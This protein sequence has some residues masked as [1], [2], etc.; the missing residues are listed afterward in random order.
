ME[1]RGETPRIGPRTGATSR[2]TAPSTGATL[3]RTA[4]TPARSVPK[5]AA[6]A[7]GLHN[8]SRRTARAGDGR[9]RGATERGS[10][11]R[12]RRRLERTQSGQ[13]FRRGGGVER[14][15][16]SRGGG[17]GRRR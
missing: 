8:S 1:E 9:R 4:R 16:S 13:A 7:P 10:H 12:T 17:G 5:P 15:S 14:R 3:P 11:E 2:R 6:T